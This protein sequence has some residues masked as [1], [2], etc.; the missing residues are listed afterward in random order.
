MQNIMEFNI[1]TTCCNTSDDPKCLKIN[2]MLDLFY[3]ISIFL[4]KIS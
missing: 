4:S 3:L 2:Y 1:N